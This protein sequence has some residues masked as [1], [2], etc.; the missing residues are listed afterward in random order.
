[1][2]TPPTFDARHILQP[3]VFQEMP[4]RCQE[5]ERER[6]RRSLL[7]TTKPPPPSLPSPHINSTY[8]RLLGKLARRLRGP[9]I[10]MRSLACQ[11]GQPDW[12]ETNYNGRRVTRVTDWLTDCAV[13]I[14]HLCSPPVR[15][16]YDMYACTITHHIGTWSRWN[17]PQDP[18]VFWGEMRRSS[19]YQ[20]PE[21]CS[22]NSSTWIYEYSPRVD[23]LFI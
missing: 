12:T 4:K 20:E 10:W 6:W 19:K 16:A 15:V 11:N 9:K 7:I 21:M 1:M 18:T 23:D 17:V 2:Q 8:R 14:A 5:R 3:I 13:N 22:P